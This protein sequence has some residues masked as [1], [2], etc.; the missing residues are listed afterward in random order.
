MKTD[1]HNGYGEVRIADA[2]D[3]LYTLPRTKEIAR[4]LYAACGLPISVFMRTEDRVYKQLFKNE[5]SLMQGDLLSPALF[6]LA[7]MPHLEAARAELRAKMKCEEIDYFAYIDDIVWLVPDRP[8]A[9]A[10]V[11]EVLAEHLKPVSSKISHNK[12]LTLY[13][14]RTRAATAL[15]DFPED[16]AERQKAA[17]TEFIDILGTPFIG[18]LEGFTD[19]GRKGVQAFVLSRMMEGSRGQQHGEKLSRLGRDA[20]APHVPQAL[21]LIRRCI[22]P[23]T[24]Y[25]LRNTPASMSTEAVAAMDAAVEDTLQKLLRMTKEPFND[26]QRD[27]ISLPLT[28]G[29]LGIQRLSSVVQEMVRAASSTTER[30]ASR[31]RIAAF[32]RATF[33]NLVATLREVQAG[34]DPQASARASLMLAHLEDYDRDERDMVNTT[35]RLVFLAD[36]VETGALLLK[37]Y[38]MMGHIPVTVSG[39]DYK[40]AA[41]GELVPVG[42]R[43]EHGNRCDRIGRTQR[44]DELRNDALRMAR[45]AFQDAKGEEGFPY[46]NSAATDKRAP[47]KEIREQRSDLSIVVKSDRKPSGRQKIRADFAVT[48][49][50]RVGRFNAERAKRLKYD[51]IKIYT[52]EDSIIIPAVMDTRGTMQ[53]ECEQ[54]LR[55]I[56]KQYLIVTTGSWSEARVQAHLGN[57]QAKCLQRNYS[58][59]LRTTPHGTSIR[60]ASFV[61]DSINVDPLT[62]IVTQVEGSITNRKRE[63]EME[64]ERVYLA[65][66]EAGEAPLDEDLDDDDAES[67]AGSDTE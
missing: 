58:M 55:L 26:N 3:R 4:H 62:F 5:K 43:L 27:I 42:E 11:L 2:L 16:Q 59:F 64:R 29:G 15:A 25:I 32:H 47:P 35:G 28:S 61:F 24:A 44:H 23:S 60:D 36:D 67:G 34:N 49:R 22:I 46:A 18:T 53:R 1:L 17:S 30:S 12:T 13:P 52:T 19:A 7:I 10:T 45:Y 41:C 66:V 51:R 14:P 54:L 21:T 39:P 57:F 40:C 8:G 56:V 6:S 37:I 48:S 33:R 31:Q 63:Q 50:G 20:W 38:G 65:L 9:R